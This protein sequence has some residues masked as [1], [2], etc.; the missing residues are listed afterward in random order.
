MLMVTTSR[1][2]P[3]MVTAAPIV[4]PRRGATHLVQPNVR[5][6]ARLIRRIREIT[7]HYVW[8][9]H[10][11][12]N[13]LDGIL[14]SKIPENRRAIYDAVKLG[15]DEIQ[16]RAVTIDDYQRYCNVIGGL[17]TE[18]LAR[19]SR[20]GDMAERLFTEGDELAGH[21][22]NVAYLA[23]NVGMHLE[24]YIIK[25]RQRTAVP[26]AARDL[27][28]LGVGAIL[29]DLGK[30]QGPREAR[31]Q[32]E[33]TSD[34]HP[35]YPGHVAAG[36]QMLRDRI[37]PVAATIALHHHQRWDGSGWPDMD[38]LTAG[39]RAGPLAGRQIHVFARIVA[40]ANLFDNLTTRPDGSSR[41]AIF[42]L[43]AMQTEKF[44]CRLDPVI[45]KAFLRFLPPFPTGVEV[46]LS[47]RRPAAVIEIDRD[48]PCR[49]KVRPLDEKSE[50]ADIDLRLRPDLSIA[51]SQGVKVGR[52]L[53]DLSGHQQTPAASGATA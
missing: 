32:H 43:Y 16:N 7:V 33:V 46:I 10:P 11:L 15:F 21:C 53:Y 24:H 17:I 36:F 8:V 47:N 28:S 51:E 29:H 14:L 23:V 3:G 25:E 12:M 2:V 4:H 13:D 22:A 37:N 38:E 44:A 30:L 41:P 34:R 27:T 52:W 19:D 5:L 1:L 18:L 40:A 6:D 9:K 20:A 50:I 35:A 45:L 48:Q 42:A 31:S 39:R 49:P 26:A